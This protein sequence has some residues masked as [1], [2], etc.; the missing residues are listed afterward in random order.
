[1]SWAVTGEKGSLKTSFSQVWFVSWNFFCRVCTCCVCLK[2][3]DYIL[4]GQK[5]C[6]FLTGTGPILYP[7]AGLRSAKNQFSSWLVDKHPWDTKQNNTLKIKAVIDQLSEPLFSLPR[8]HNTS[9]Q[10]WINGINIT[11]GVGGSKNHYYHLLA[12]RR[13]DDND[14]I[15]QNV[16]LEL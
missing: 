7:T 15:S 12:Q 4:V 8:K 2:N 16:C 14:E 13:N 3:C 11:L 10:S 6:F 5:T 9:P 1:M